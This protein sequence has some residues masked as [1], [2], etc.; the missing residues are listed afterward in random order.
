MGPIKRFEDIQDWQEARKLVRMIYHLTDEGALAS[1]FGLRSQI[2]SAAVS[3]LAN[4]TEGFDCN[5]P[6]EFGRFLGIARRSA[7]E[8]Q[9][10]STRH[11]MWDISINSDS[12]RP[13]N[14]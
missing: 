12:I 14:R 3:A 5:S 13:M 11:S 2:Q 8:V 9:S 10:L 6:T 7:V 1:D 4:I